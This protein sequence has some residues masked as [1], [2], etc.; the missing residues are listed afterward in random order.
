[1]HQCERGCWSDDD[2]SVVVEKAADDDEAV[3]AV[4]V[5]LVFVVGSSRGD[6]TTRSKITFHNGDT[7]HHRNILIFQCA[8]S[9][10]NSNG[11]FEYNI[12]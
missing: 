2:G 4:T 9:L 8:E 1:M 10:A 7:G 12:I 5:V 6:T 3:K 11:C